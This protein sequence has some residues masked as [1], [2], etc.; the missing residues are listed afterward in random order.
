ME[1]R[2]LIAMWCAHR[3]VNIEMSKQYVQNVPASND[4][5]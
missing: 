5:V 4:C 2:K 3:K 1:K